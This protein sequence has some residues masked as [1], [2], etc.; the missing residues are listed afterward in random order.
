MRWDL[1]DAPL[2]RELRDSNEN[3]HRLLATLHEAPVQPDEATEAIRDAEVQLKFMDDAQRELEAK[4]SSPR[5][6]EFVAKASDHI[7]E[8][9][10]RAA[11]AYDAVR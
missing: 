7:A 3:L 2:D 5:A 1:G 9:M 6:T 8:S 4:R 10:E 11:A